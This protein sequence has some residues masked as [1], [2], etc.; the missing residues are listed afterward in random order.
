VWTATAHK[1]A[2][3]ITREATARKFDAD[4]G[5]DPLFMAYT[6]G[7]DG[8]KRRR[9]GRNLET[10]DAAVRLCSNFTRKFRRQAAY[11]EAGH[12]VV[13]HLLGFTGVWINM[14]DG[15]YRAIVR[16]D[17]L[18]VL[19]AVTDAAL[20]SSGG[21]G[22][23][24]S[25]GGGGAALARYLYEDLMFLTAGLVAEAKIAGYR[26]NYVEEDVAGRTS[27]IPWSAIRVARI[28][29]GLPI[30]GHKDCEIPFDTG[31]IDAGP[32]RDR[33]ITEADVAAVIKR[34]EDE[35]FGL[36]KTNWPLVKRVTNALC[37]QDRLTVA[38]FEAL[39]TG[40]GST[41]L[42]PSVAPASVA[43]SSAWLKGA[44]RGPPGQT[45]PGCELQESTAPAYSPP[46]VAPTVRL[47]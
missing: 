2:F 21:S 31:P 43:A 32:D 3:T 38:E 6:N 41:G 11:H 45:K 15:P 18:P 5:L 8:S 7:L 28:E 37:K 47:F 29:A 14:E 42:D 23:G 30:C 25:G 19:L 22:G 44:V 16:H 34:A 35:V 10:F 20:D 24:G 36:L 1:F 13:A 39:I 4:V 40:S 46:A 9:I 12:A 33:S 26:T 27:I 17:Y